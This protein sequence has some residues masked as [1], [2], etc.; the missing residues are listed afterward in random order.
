MKLVCLP[1]TTASK[2][3]M[4]TKK[5]AEDLKIR[6]FLCSVG[7]CIETQFFEDFDK[8]YI[9]PFLLL[10][11][12]EP[13][14]RPEFLEDYKKHKDD[15]KTKFP[16]PI[17]TKK[18]FKNIPGGEFLGKLILNQYESVPYPEFS[19]LRNLLTEIENWSTN[20]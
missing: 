18:I 15:F 5:K 12:D 2:I 1:T 9:E 16:M 13:L 4:N 14:N 3:F 10:L 11:S 20:A 17:L 8:E 7:N 19:V 6:L